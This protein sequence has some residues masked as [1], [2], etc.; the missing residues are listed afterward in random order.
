MPDLGKILL[1]V[2][3]HDLKNNPHRRRYV[4]CI[5]GQQGALRLDRRHLFIRDERLLKMLPMRCWRRTNFHRRQIV[6]GCRFYR[7][8]ANSGWS[9]PAVLSPVLHKMAARRARRR[10]GRNHDG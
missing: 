3:Q 5:V 2:C 10:T 7:W 6:G 8:P 1:I 4:V 9:L